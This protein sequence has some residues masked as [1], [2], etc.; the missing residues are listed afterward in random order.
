[1]DA[2]MISSAGTPLTVRTVTV[3][4]PW[5]AAASLTI[6]SADFLTFSWVSGAGSNCPAIPQ[7][8]AA[9]GATARTVTE[10][11]RSAASSRAQSSAFMEWADPSTPTTM[12]DISLPPVLAICHSEGR[13]FRTA[14][15]EA[16][17]L[18]YRDFLRLREA[19]VPGPAALVDGARAGYVPG[20]ARG[21]Q[22]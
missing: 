19:M 12:P 4:W 2:L 5:R 9:A 16:Q 1:S 15:S 22:S 18:V 21:A 3:C 20:S 8:L 7:I 10:V 13:S 11:F 14:L 17:R 6:S